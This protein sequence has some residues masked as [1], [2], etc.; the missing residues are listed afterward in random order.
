MTVSVIYGADE[1]EFDQL[2]GMEF[3]Q[4]VDIVRRAMSIPDD[5]SDIRLNG[6]EVP[7]TKIVDPESTV[8]FYKRSGSKGCF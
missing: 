7:R 5:V 6:R 2:D 8:S 3:G 4:V 1:M